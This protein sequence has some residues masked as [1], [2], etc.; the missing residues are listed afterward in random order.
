MLE[1]HERGNQR[2]PEHE[3]GKAEE[4]S[5]VKKTPAQTG[6]KAGEKGIGL[7]DSVLAPLTILEK[8]N[9][10]IHSLDSADLYLVFNESYG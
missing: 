6:S 9:V 7:F 4:E 3:Q 2:W 1:S 5:G 10:S 8:K